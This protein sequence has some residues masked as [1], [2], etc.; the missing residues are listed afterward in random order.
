MRINTESQRGG[1][2][3]SV[4][5]IASAL[6]HF[7]KSGGGLE[8]RPTLS[9]I[10]RPARCEVGK[11]QSAVQLNGPHKGDYKPQRIPVGTWERRRCEGDRGNP[12]EK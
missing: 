1:A 3:F 7:D 11:F 10:Q 4:V 6:G 12:S 9:P 5:G 2:H 8:S